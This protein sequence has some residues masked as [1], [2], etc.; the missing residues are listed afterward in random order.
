[1]EEGGFSIDDFRLTLKAAP[2]F[3][4]ASIENR[5]SEMER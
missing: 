4:G 2:S 1:M 3:G 5:K